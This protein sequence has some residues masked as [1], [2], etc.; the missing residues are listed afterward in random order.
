MVLEYLSYYTPPSSLDA[1]APLKNIPIYS[2]LLQE[3][4]SSYSLRITK[5]Y[6]HWCIKKDKP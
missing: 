5:A 1:V 2:S 3:P 6:L 4:P